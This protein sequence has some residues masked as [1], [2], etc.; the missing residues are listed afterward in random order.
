MTHGLE[1]TT[2]TP[3]PRSGETMIRANGVDLC[4]ETFGDAGDPA[5]LLIG[6]GAGAMDWWED[7]FCERLAAGGRHVI[8][9]DHRDTGRSASYPAGTPGYT[10]RDLAADPIGILDALGIARAHLAGLSMGGG[11]AQLLALEHPERVATLTLFATSPVQG[12]DLDLPPVGEALEATSDA[13]GPP[14]DW[15]D[16]AAA[17]TAIVEGE[18]PYAGELG[19]DE[20][21]VR[22]IAAR[23]VDRTTDIE[24]SMTNHFVL[25]DGEPIRSGLDQIV[26]PTLVL[27][28][29]SDPLFPM[30]HAE[31]LVREIPD[32]RLIPLEGVGHQY[33]P[34]QVWDVVIPAMLA[35]TSA[36]R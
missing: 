20:D 4:I 17:I 8:R 32:A 16:R 9:Y 35:H 22:A 11:I 25:D 29:T 5:I 28:G 3:V 26:A 10:Y 30:G 13:P 23:V 6:G 19:F 31:A 34:R 15:S 2:G 36:P 24:A 14:P 27:H 12:D 33:P 1:G 18:R 21:H 7:A